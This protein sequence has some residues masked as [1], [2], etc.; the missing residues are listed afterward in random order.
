M[1]ATALQLSS[2]LFKSLLGYGDTGVDNDGTLKEWYQEFILAKPLVFS[3]QIWAQA[4]DIPATAPTLSDQQISGVVQYFENVPLEPVDTDLADELGLKSRDCFHLEDLKDSIPLN[5]GDGSYI[6]QIKFPDG[7]PLAF[8]F[9][10]WFLDNASGILQFYGGLPP[11]ITRENPPLIS[12]YKYVGEKGGGGSASITIS[13]TEP[14]GASPGAMW[15]NQLTGDLL[16]YY[17]DGD[18]QQWVSAISGAGGLW[19]LDTATST[20]STPYTVAATAK[21]FKIS[22]PLES[23]SETHDLMHTSVESAKA[24]LMYR[25][26]AKCVDGEVEINLD[27]AGNM[28]EGTFVSLCSD[29]SCFVTNSTN[30]SQVRGKVTGNILKIESMDSGVELDISWLVVATRSDPTISSLPNVDENGDYFTEIEKTESS[31]SVD[32]ITISNLNVN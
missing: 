28:T 9:K 11:G 27:E 22:H 1:A 4:D 15:W 24:E 25:G 30:W 7:N 3:S 29:P 21:A 6:Y 23:M 20:I 31:N 8:G 19:S 17:D 16:L 18:S 10:D 26:K 14:E 5:Y 12:F 2:T 13:A 32:N